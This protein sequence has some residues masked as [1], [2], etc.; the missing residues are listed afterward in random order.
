MNVSFLKKQTD[1]SMTIII[2][3]LC[4]TTVCIV[5]NTLIVYLHKC[6]QN[7]FIL[8]F[9]RVSC[10]SIIINI[11]KYIKLE[12]CLSLSGLEIDKMK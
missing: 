8:Y 9:Q 7:M 10:S 3:I 11:L 5:Q 1:F 12:H 6:S 4:Q 2:F